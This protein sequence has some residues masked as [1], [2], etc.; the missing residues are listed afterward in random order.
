MGFTQCHGFSCFS[1]LPTSASCISVCCDS[2]AVGLTCVS[3][4]ERKHVILGHAQCHLEGSSG[5]PKWKQHA[6]KVIMGWE[7]CSGVRPSIYKQRLPFLHGDRTTWGGHSQSQ[8]TPIVSQ[9]SLHTSQD[10]GRE[11][12]VYPPGSFFSMLGPQE[13]NMT[14][15]S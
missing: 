11:F 10:S 8:L 15:P 13:E 3:I 5:F 7:A 9:E 6:L 12:P 14:G 1:Q 2:R 4:S